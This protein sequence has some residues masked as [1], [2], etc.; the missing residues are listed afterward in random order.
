MRPS[1]W[2]Q[3]QVM[4]QDKSHDESVMMNDR[5]GE[6]SHRPERRDRDFMGSNEQNP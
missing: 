1:T 3:R 6:S 4:S 2:K 5:W